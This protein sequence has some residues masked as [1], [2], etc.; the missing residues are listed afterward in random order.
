MGL[1][2]EVV[3]EANKFDVICVGGGIAGMAAATTLA[4]KNLKVCFLEK[5]VPGGKLMRIEA[6][7][8]LQ[9]YEGINGA[10]FANNY[11][12]YAVNQT[13]ARY[14][15][16]NVQS[17]KLKADKIY[18]WTEDGQAWETKALIIAVGTTINHLN[19]PS[20]EKF[21]NK[22]V[23]YCVLC[24]SSLAKD[25]NVVLIGNKTHL[26]HLQQCAKNVTVLSSNEVKDY[27][28]SNNVEGIIKSD[29]T[30]LPCDM[31]FVENGFKTDLSFLVPEIKINDKNEIQVHPNMATTCEGVFAC[32]DCTNGTKLISNAINQAQTAANS[33]EQYIRSKKW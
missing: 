20:E 30:Q 8:N 17:M 13:K 18:L 31:V 6:I 32:G 10:A 26:D 15:F 7:H 33:A 19:L 5:D 29:G 4:Q 24:D 28:G 16:G 9:G 21:L 14:I 11:F 3:G 2:V 25:K 1:E 12:E 22:G 23:S 27:Y